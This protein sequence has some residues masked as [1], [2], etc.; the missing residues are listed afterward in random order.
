MVVRKS[1][2]YDIEKIMQR[3]DQLFETE[4]QKFVAKEWELEKL[5]GL[6]KTKEKEVKAYKQEKA[7]SLR[8]K[9][10]QIIKMSNTI[11]QMTNTI[12]QKT[13]IINQN[14]LKIN[15]LTKDIKR[16]VKDCYCQPIS[17]DMRARYCHL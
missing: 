13:D 14:N 4:G 5:D 1:G 17:E 11:A 2:L 16:T 15:R 9:D 3:V 8:L 7:A 12:T 6:M 10:E